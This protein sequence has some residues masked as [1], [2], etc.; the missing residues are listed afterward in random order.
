MES[1]VHMISLEYRCANPFI[2][3]WKVANHADEKPC[4]NL[5]ALGEDLRGLI[6][7]QGYIGSSPFKRLSYQ[8]CGRGPICAIFT[9]IW[10]HLDFIMW[11]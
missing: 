7:S 8:T 3:E 4:V 5:I 6:T 1:I 2:D 10:V 9:S 11:R